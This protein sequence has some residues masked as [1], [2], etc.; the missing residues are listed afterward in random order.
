[1]TEKKSVLVIGL[2]PTLI[3]FSDPDDAAYPGMDAAKVL[4]K[5]SGVETC[6]EA[7]GHPESSSSRGGDSL[8]STARS[9]RSTKSITL[10]PC[11]RSV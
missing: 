2:Q 9:A 5:R 10:R 7:N 3:D 6:P 11:N 1:M 4:G 8:N